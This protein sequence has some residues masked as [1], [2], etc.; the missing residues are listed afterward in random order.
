MCVLYFGKLLM[1]EYHYD[2]F[3]SKH[4]N[5]SRPSFTDTNSLMYGIKTDFIKILVSIKKFSNYLVKSKYYDD[6]NKSVVDKMKDETGDVC[7]WT[8]NEFVGLKPKMYLFL[9]DDT[10]EHRKAK[11]MNKNVV[12]TMSHD[13]NKDVFSR[14]N[15]WD[16]QWMEYKVKI[17]KW[18]PV[19]STKFLYHALII[20]YLF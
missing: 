19:K 11:S 8:G 12:T 6:S 4:G 3:K 16:I 13:E 14:I 7:I 18:E 17:I 10:T 20:K 2:Y 1:H 15:I 9:V 5:K